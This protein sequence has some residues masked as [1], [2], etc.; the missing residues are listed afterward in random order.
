MSDKNEQEHKHI[1]GYNQLLKNIKE[2]VDHAEDEISNKFNHAL[3]N[4]KGS[5]P[6]EFSLVLV[7]PR[8]WSHY[9]VSDERIR[10][11]YHVDGPLTE[12]AVVLTDDAV[13]EALLAGTL[14]AD[15]ALEAGLIA[16]A[17]PDQSRVSRLLAS[18]LARG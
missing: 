10:A 6:T 2:L 15:Q 5:E 9:R 4:A 7:G 14:D 11:Q 16:V 8:L 1:R 12:R 18:A 13:I 17:G 3:D